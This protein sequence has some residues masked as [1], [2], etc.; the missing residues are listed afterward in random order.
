MAIVDS[1]YALIGYHELRH[2]TID[3]LGCPEMRFDA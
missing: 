2:L 3:I 1:V